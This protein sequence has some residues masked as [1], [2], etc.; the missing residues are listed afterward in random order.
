M[1]KIVVYFKLNSGVPAMVM[2]VKN[3]SEVINFPGYTRYVV[4][5][6]RIIDTLNQ[7]VSLSTFFAN[8]DK[9]G[10]DGVDT[11]KQN[12]SSALDNRKINTLS[13][14]SSM[15]IGRTNTETIFSVL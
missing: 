7:P 4:D 10:F 5:P 6:T 13:T 11:L 2:C 9:F 14:D 8:F 3:E 15:S 1:M 12:S